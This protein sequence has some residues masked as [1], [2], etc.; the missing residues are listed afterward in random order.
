MVVTVP[1]PSPHASYCNLIAAH[2]GRVMLSSDMSASSMSVFDAFTGL[3]T[4]SCFEVCWL[5]PTEEAPFE[6]QRYTHGM[7]VIGVL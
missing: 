6:H 2:I 1:C 4:V 7:V 5:P 3:E